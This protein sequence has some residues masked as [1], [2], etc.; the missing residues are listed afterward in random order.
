[1]YNLAMVVPL[2]DNFFYKIQNQKSNK[3]PLYKVAIFMP[4][5][6]KKTFIMQI[7]TY[8]N[9]TILYNVMKIKT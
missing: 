9:L 6:R 3:L 7:R 8:S 1:M 5:R 2:L 4:L